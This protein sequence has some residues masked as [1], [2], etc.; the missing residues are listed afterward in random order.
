[1]KMSDK[2]EIHN[3]L[4]EANHLLM[5]KIQ[6]ITDENELKEILKI[7]IEIEKLMY[8]LVS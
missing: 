3:K 6:E 8:K 5:E 7:Q 1:M 4:E 2:W